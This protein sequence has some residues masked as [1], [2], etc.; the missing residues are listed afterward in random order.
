MLY[1]TILHLLAGA[2]TGMVFKI[3]TLLI[4]LCFVVFEPIALALV[5]SSIPMQI[6]IANFV[7]VQLG[8]FIGIYGRGALEHA[9]SS[10]GAVHTRHIP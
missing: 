8:Y 5:Q 9:V 3:R 1:A 7:V 6:I 10:P 2:L 4:L